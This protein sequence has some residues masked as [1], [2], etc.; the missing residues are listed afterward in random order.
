MMAAA[1]QPADVR[2]IPGGHEWPVW[3][4]LWADFLDSQFSRQDRSL[5]SSAAASNS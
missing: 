3:T 2:V 1:L 5:Q 4:Q